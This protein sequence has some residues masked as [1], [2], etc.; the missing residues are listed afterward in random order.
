MLDPIAK[1]RTRRALGETPPSPP[2]EFARIVRFGLAGFAN[3]IVGFGIIAALD[4]GLRVPPAIANMAG[5]A[6]GIALSF[7]L[8]HHFVFRSRRAVKSSGPRFLISAAIAFL[9][10]LAVLMAAGH[11][12]GSAPSSRLAAQALG[13]G[14]YTLILFVLGRIW[15]FKA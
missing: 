5:Y 10:N 4:I 8:N 7:F 2:Q 11:F 6:V 9:A 15:A 1:L 14:A 13:V 3:S 12:L